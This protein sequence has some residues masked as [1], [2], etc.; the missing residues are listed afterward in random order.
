MNGP[1]DEP[2]D[3]TQTQETPKRGVPKPG[4]SAP[5]PPMP[6]PP[7]EET[8]PR[9]VDSPP[10]ATQAPVLLRAQQRILEILVAKEE[11]G[12]VL[13]EVCLLFEETVEGSKCSIMLHEQVTHQLR[14]GAAPSLDEDFKRAMEVVSVGPQ[15]ASCG[16]AVHHG[17]TVV[18]EDVA[19]NRIWRDYRE[20]AAEA[21]LRSCWSIPLR[22]AQPDPRGERRIVGTVDFYFEDV[23]QYTA[24]QLEILTAASDLASCVLHNTQTR[25][26]LNERQHYDSLTDLPNRGLYTQRLRQLI[27]DAKSQSKDSQ[28]RFAVAVV[29]LDDFKEVN[30]TLGF[31]MGDLVLQAVGQRLAGCLHESDTIARSGSDDFL[32]LIQ[33]LDK[34]FDVGVIAEKIL[35]RVNDPYDFDGYPLYVTASMGISVY[36]WD[37]DDAQILLRNA[38]TALVSAKERGGSSYEQF[39]PTM[40]RNRP[41][42]ERWFEQTRLASQLRGVLHRDELELYYQ[43]KYADDRVTVCGAEALLRWQHPELG[44]L[45]PNQFLPLAERMGLTVPFGEWCL[46]TACRQNKHWQEQGLLH[47]P[48]SVNVSPLQFRH[49][50]LLSSIERTLQVSGLDPKYL[51]LEIIERLAMEDNQHNQQRLDALH[52]LGLCLSIDDFGTGFS[53]LSYLSRFPFDTIKIDR[54]F[55]KEIGTG[56]DRDKDSRNIVLAIISMARAL[57]IKV[58]AEGVETEEQ[59]D[60]LFQNECD[61]IQGFYFARPEPAEKVTVTLQKVLES[62]MPL[63]EAARRA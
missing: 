5:K 57:S 55:I 22:K 30:D 2:K 63:S 43:L 56:N 28:L 13:D 53:S 15:S 58:V 42:V 62:R 59:V 45:L 36:P 37:G 12:D 10:P 39:R 19:S 47:F 32:L 49:G 34:D 20:Q 61:V 33:G 3:V 31:Q 7:S 14:M 8:G 35:R 27:E 26:S 51:E 24:S 11:L 21:G 16:A 29:D 41:T 6:E 48:V 18:A 17:K 44:L 9:L 4:P 38:E 1:P 46:E 60:F 52:D 50:Q 25:V 54:S 23:R 40:A